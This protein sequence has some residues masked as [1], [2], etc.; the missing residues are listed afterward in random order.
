MT[1]SVKDR[2]ALEM[3]LDAQRRGRLRPGSTII[4]PTSGNTGIALAAIAAELGYRCII[5]MPDSMSLE[6][7]RMI[8]DYGAQVVLTPGALGMAGS[9]E[10]AGKLAAEEKDSFV[11]NQFSNPANAMAHYRTTGPEI[12][13]QMSG[14]ADIF[15][16]G[17]GTGGTITGTGRYLKEQNGEIRIVAVEPSKSPLLSAGV[18]GQHAIEGI[19]ANFV[20]EVLDVTLLDQIVTVTDEQA[21]AATRT[22]IRQGLP[23]GLS[24][25]AAYFAAQMLAR[26]W[27]QKNVVTIL[28]DSADRYATIL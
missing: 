19:G 9:V 4:E 16:A 21:I 20:P 17:V 24:A 8:A 15:V 12:W 28:P 1:G 3:I 27:P 5:V 10:M 13:R 26:Q 14:K 11:P 18:A 6:R 23:A 2:A 25:G 7:R 22:L